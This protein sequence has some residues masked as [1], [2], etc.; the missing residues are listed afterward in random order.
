V[1]LEKKGEVREG[2]RDK[3]P[4][5][6]VYKEMTTSALDQRSEGASGDAVDHWTHEDV[7]SKW[8]EGG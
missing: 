8:L 6:M 2:G 4:A 7:R 5:A 1:N 3:R